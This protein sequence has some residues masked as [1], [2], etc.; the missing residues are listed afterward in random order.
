MNKFLEFF[1]GVSGEMSS[2]RLGYLSTIPVSSVGTIWICDRLI[3]SGNAALAVQV[4]DS[5]LIFSAVLGGFVSVELI[6][7]IIASFRGKIASVIKPK[8]EDQNVENNT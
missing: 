6:P 3:D 4:W 1:Q 2:K 8:K 5:F 7:G